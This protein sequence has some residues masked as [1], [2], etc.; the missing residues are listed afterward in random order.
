[1]STKQK[2]YI[3]FGQK[4]R[5]EPHPTFDKADPDGV[6]EVEADNADEAREKVVAK[7]GE[8]WSFIYPA[9]ELDLD[10]F[11]LGVIASI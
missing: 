6:L 3:T 10:N 9:D 11:P 7:L 2:F 8:F 4:Y 5:T 1:M